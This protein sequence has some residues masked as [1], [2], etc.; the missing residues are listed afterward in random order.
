MRFPKSFTVLSAFVVMA[1]LITSCGPAVM[2]TTAPEEEGFVLALPRITL[3]FAADG[4]PTLEGL[5]LEQI[6][7]LLKAYTGQDVAAYISMLRIDPFWV[8]WMT[9]AN[10]QHIEIQYGAGGV[11]LFANAKLLPHLAWSGESLNNA[12]AATETFVGQSPMMGMIK[13]FLPFVRNTGIGLVL[14]FPMADGAAEIAVRA[15][16]A[17][18][19]MAASEASPSI[20][21]KAEVS[22]DNTGVPTLKGFDYSAAQLAEMS[23]IPALNMV[24]LP[25]ALIAQM[26]ALNIQHVEIRSRSNGIFIYV[27]GM[28]MPHLAWNDALL[29]DSAGLYAQMNPGSPLIELVNFLAPALAAADVNMIVNFPVAAGAMV[30]PHAARS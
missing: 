8:S 28:E 6:A 14:K 17:V 21:F 29:A 1:L 22:Y 27:N 20:V 16:G 3:S 2:P 19:E 23:G 12:I 25:P 5:N 18:A 26:Q 10:I 9:N 11:V 7:P 13:A 24:A 30:I 4:T 15:P